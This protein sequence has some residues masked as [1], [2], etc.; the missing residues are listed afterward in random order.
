MLHI[1]IWLTWQMNYHGWA[2]T[3]APFDQWPSISS[4]LL[5]LAP[6]L[7][8]PCLSINWFRVDSRL[9]LRK[10]PFFCLVFW[11]S[12]WKGLFCNSLM[13]VLLDNCDNSTLT[14]PFV[15]G[16]CFNLTCFNRI[17]FNCRI[18][19]TVFITFRRLENVASSFVPAAKSYSIVVKINIKVAFTSRSLSSTPT[20][21]FVYHSL[22]GFH[23]IAAP[24]NHL[25]VFFE[26]K[27][28][29]H[30]ELPSAGISL[31]DT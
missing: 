17:Y 8:I 29:N 4:D 3:I 21:T 7:M 27:P 20:E 10:D 12:F 23:K 26:F 9:S 25:F 11:T 15:I 19:A 30:L 2:G 18:M 28:F 6:T 13:I 16:S 24:S 31:V 14:D 22:S 1:W 5:I